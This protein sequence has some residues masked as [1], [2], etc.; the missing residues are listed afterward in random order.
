MGVPSLLKLCITSVAQIP[1]LSAADLAFSPDIL[2]L[3]ASERTRFIPLTIADFEKFFN[4]DSTSVLTL[5]ASNVSLYLLL[6]VRMW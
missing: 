2:D 5:H 1:N 6:K 4:N 3:I